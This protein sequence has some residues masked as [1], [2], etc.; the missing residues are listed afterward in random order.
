MG[1]S[2]RVRAAIAVPP[3]QV[4][5][6]G[7]VLGG[8]AE[9]AAVD[10]RGEAHGAEGLVRRGLGRRAVGDHEGLAVAR[11]AGLE[12]EGELGVAVG[13]VWLVLADGLK[14]FG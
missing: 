12:E 4:L 3:R 1:R 14:T 11:E 7:N 13:H 10:Q 2:K 9:L 6:V 8:L 5:F